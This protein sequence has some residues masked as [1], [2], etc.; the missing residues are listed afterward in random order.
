[1]IGP[2][3]HPETGTRPN[4]R[5][6]G[7]T[8]RQLTS[9]SYVVLGLLMSFGPATSY[10]LKKRSADTVGNFWIFAHS[11]LYDEPVRLAEQGVVTQETERGG[12]HRRT[13]RITAA[14][15]DAVRD[16]LASPTPGKTEVRDPGLL[17][18]FFGGLGTPD[19][20]AAPSAAHPEEPVG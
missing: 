19:D 1:M 10:E 17:K 9:T 16:W 5:G 11:Q 6:D 7:E 15:R 14:G 12:R 4:W 13:F 8:L 3:Y 20:I 2:D 18:L